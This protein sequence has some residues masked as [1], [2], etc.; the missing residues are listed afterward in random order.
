[1][2]TSKPSCWSST[3]GES[4]NDI[5]EDRCLRRMLSVLF[6]VDAVVMMKI[7]ET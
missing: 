5:F 2:A 7:T 1:M 4:I 3:H 6:F